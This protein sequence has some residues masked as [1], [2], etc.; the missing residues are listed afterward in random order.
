MPSSTFAGLK[1]W[2]NQFLAWL[3]D[4]PLG[5]D[6]AAEENNHGTWYDAQLTA[7]AIF[8]G[9]KNLAV[10]ICEAAK[11]KRD[12]LNGDAKTYELNAT[13]TAAAIK[14]AETVEAVNDLAKDDDRQTVIKAA[15]KRIGELS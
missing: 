5:K 2:M 3:L 1:A 11:A 7:L 15:A 13:K 6:E 10:E 8:A 4:S 9:R 14:A 12:G